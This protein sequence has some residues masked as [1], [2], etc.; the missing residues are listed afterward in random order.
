MFILSL[1]SRMTRRKYRKKY[2]FG[3]A[4]TREREEVITLKKIMTM[5]GSNIKHAVISVEYTIWLQKSNERKLKPNRL[6]LY[7]YIE[8]ELF[9]NFELPFLFNCS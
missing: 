6:I 5:L 9:I 8:W 3:R 7:L 1:L 4:G 2:G